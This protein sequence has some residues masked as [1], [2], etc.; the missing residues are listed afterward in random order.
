MTDLGKQNATRAAQ[1]LAAVLAAACL[2]ACGGG[3]GTSGDNNGGGI[4]DA[5]PPAPNEAR[6]DA[7]QPN[8]VVDYFKAKIAQRAA[9]GLPGTAVTVPTVGGLASSG[10]VVT[11]TGTSLLEAAVEEDSLIKTDGSMLYGLHRAYV[12]GTVNE[13]ARLSAVSRLADGSLMSVGR[14]TL[15]AQY[16]PSGLYIT[17]GGTRVAALSQQDPYYGRQTVNPQLV[18]EYSRKLS[19]DLFNV[20]KTA[21][22]SQT[23]RIRIDGLL[24]GSRMIGNVLY[25]VSTWSPDLTR[26]NV[27]AGSTAQ[28]TT[29]ALAGLD[30]AALLPTIQV[31]GAAAQPLVTESQCLLH[32]AN[33]SF[34]LQ[35]TTITAIDLSS[36]T[37]TRNSRCV[38]GGS[39]GLYMGPA[40]IYVATSRQY[41]YT[42]SV[43]DTV[44]PQNSK[45][46]IHKFAVQGTQISYRASTS[47]AG[48]L[49]WDTATMPQRMSEF[50]GDL[51]VLTFTGETGQS[52]MPPVTIQNKPA[53]AAVLTVLRENATERTLT[54]LAT[55]PNAQRPAPLVRA[56]QQVDTLHFAGPRGYVTSLM[57]TE[58]M[59]I[60]DLS[61]AASPAI[62][63]E[64]AAQ[65]YADHVTALPNG[66][67]LGIGK[68][69][70]VGGSADGIQIALFDV[71]NPSQTRRVVSET[72]GVRGSLTTLNSVRAAMNITQLGTR[73][74]V[75]FPAR[76][77]ETPD[78]SSSPPVYGYQ[79]AARLEVDTAASKLTALPI[80][81]SVELRSGDQP[82]LQSRYKLENERSLQVDAALYHLSGGQTFYLIGY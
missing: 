82:E 19:V 31:D 24:V 74:R 37:F 71:A 64:V 56:G 28:A 57:R 25:V 6:L 80:L 47:V 76:V 7:A 41:R 63:G 48:H 59:T 72:L 14:A 39:E 29:A 27:P 73:V 3:G 11:N 18:A 51:R 2:A 1:G 22:P 5:T 4:D 43:L 26:F 58:P 40:S 12:N 20:S 50:Q 23:N 10:S 44:M 54:T 49:G 17:G 32:P 9:F 62:A 55:L 30:A 60:L 35:L 61:N 70:T 15:D 66:L 46:D 81:S 36:A 34:A 21:A 8:G 78:G 79:G 69:T 68:D 77:Y 67:L 33:A 13:P 42:N 16:I 52:N 38:A 65:G 75:A 45:T 53:S